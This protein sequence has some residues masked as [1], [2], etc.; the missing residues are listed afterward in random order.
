MEYVIV[1]DYCTVALSKKVTKL[2]NE[3]F[4]LVGGLIIGRDNRYCQAMV[5]I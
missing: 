1:T 3:G 5:K 2:L 4:E